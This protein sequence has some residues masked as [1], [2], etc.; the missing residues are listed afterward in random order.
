MPTISLL[1]ENASLGMLN[2]ILNLYEFIR[3]FLMKS[4]GQNKVVLPF[5]TKFT[6]LK[7]KNV[8]RPINE[9]KDNKQKQ[10]VRQSEYFYS[11]LITT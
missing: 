10:E 8:S 2:H 7:L 3:C 9:H 5:A 1:Q 4:S 11:F 6:K